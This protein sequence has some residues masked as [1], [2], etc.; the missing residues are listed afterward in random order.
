MTPIKKPIKVEI[1]NSKLVKLLEERGLVLTEAKEV[2]KQVEVLQ[3]KQQK[4]GYKMD[5]LKD[6]TKPIIDKIEVEWGE[7]EYIARL[8]VDNGKAYYEIK[9]Q[10]Q[11]YIDLLRE[12]KKDVPES[13]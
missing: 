7:F 6:K 11:D 2:Q 12:K 9:D 4:L 13:K 5:R 10:V 8:F 3:K 1:K